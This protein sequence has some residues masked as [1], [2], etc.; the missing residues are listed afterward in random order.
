MLRSEEID[1]KFTIAK[2]GKYQCFVS[3]CNDFKIL[4]LLGEI[5]ILKR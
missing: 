5:E 4:Q 1:Y 2:S 3:N